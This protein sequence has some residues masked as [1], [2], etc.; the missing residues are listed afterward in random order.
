[1]IHLTRSEIDAMPRFTR[2]NFVNSLPGFR[3]TNLCG[4]Q[5]EKGRTNLSILSSVFHL[6]SNPPLLGIQMR[7]DTVPRHTLENILATGYYT[8]NHLQ[9]EIVE[10]AHQ[11]AAGYPREISEFDATGLTP[12]HS[13]EHPAPYVA[14]SRIRMGLKLVE[15]IDIAHNGA[16]LI[17]GEVTEV[18][19]PK[20]VLGEDGFVDLQAAGSLCGSA[21]D[22]YYRTEWVSRLSY[23]KPDDPLQQIDANGRSL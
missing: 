9:E 6:G 8:L 18:F 4:T 16:H 23:P 5:D 21:L 13:P 19:L 1:M 20:E 7:P 17:I 3:A 2:A 15:K 22:A 12:W 10:A 11:S 14:E